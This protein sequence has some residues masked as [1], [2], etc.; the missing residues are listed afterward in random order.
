MKYNQAMLNVYSIFN[1]D[2]VK[3]LKSENKL[4][5]VKNLDQLE[6]IKF[7]KNIVLKDVFFKYQNNKRQFFKI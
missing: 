7:E 3:N 1:V 6:N 2:N 5:N 4:K